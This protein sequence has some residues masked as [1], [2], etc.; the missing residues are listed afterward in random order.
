MKHILQRQLEWLTL[1]TGAGANV[2][3]KFS[4]NY[5]VVLTDRTD[6]VI[7]RPGL[8]ISP[9]V[10]AVVFTFS[11]LYQPVN[12]LGERWLFAQL[13]DSYNLQLKRA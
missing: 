11:V 13:S 3:K 1:K 2:W 9:R 12:K 5:K 4:S 7:W 8:V 6:C 10:S